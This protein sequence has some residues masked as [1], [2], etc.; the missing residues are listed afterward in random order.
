MVC[1]W[2]VCS[3][4]V[5]CVR[6]VCV[7]VLVCHADPSLPPFPCLRSKRLPC[8]HSEERV[9]R[10]LGITYISVLFFESI[11]NYIY[12]FWALYELNM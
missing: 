3:V 8:V 11:S 1:V 12:I 2:C 5:L 10:D 9:D 4:C 7:L 6:C